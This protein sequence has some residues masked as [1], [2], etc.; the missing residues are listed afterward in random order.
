MRVTRLRA[1]AAA[2]AAAALLLAG[3]AESERDGGD[4][5]GD[6][7]NDA[8]FIFGAEGEVLALDPTYT[9]DSI[10]S[11]L[12]GQ[13]YDTLVRLT[14]GTVD[15][16]GGLAETWESDDTGTVWTFNL[17]EGVTFHDETAFN[18]EA[19]C[20]NFD[21]WHNLPPGINQ[22]PDMSYYWQQFSGGFA[23]NEEGRDDLSEPN[24]VSCEATD[25][26]TAVITLRNPTSRM[27]GLLVRQQFA[28]HSP[29]ALEEWDADNIGGT[30][31]APEFPEYATAHP[32]GTGPFKFE[33][34]DQA[35]GEV[36]MVRNED[37]WEEPATIAR[38]VFKA[39][40]DENA[41]RQA[42][43]S[44]EIHAY[45]QPP[46]ADW[47]TLESEEMRLEIRDSLNLL[48]IAFTQNSNEALED[49]RVRQALAHALDRQAMVTAV[50]AEGAEVATQFM[51]PALSGWNPDVPTYDY[52]PDRARDLLADAGY[53]EGELEIDFYWP[54]DV[55][56]P[57]MP[58][59]QSIFEL[60]QADLDEVGV[61]VNAVS[62]PWTPNYLSNVQNGEADLHFLGWTAD[63]PHAYNFLGTWFSRQLPQWGFDN[64][65]IFDGLAEADSE[66][67]EA[68][69]TAMFEQLNAEIM[70]YLPG[71]PIS[72]TP[73]AMVFAPNVTGVS[74]SPLLDERFGT[75]QIG[76]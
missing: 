23:E 62:E 67:D 4:D 44:G 39:I 61:T 68:A 74:A 56:R 50:M 7:D 12:N 1:V 5:T 8:T 66:A 46:P 75:A 6:T 52:D 51:P 71:I 16:E 69:Q 43:L 19:V 15:I 72:H 65:A 32:T 9:S 13:I 27:V 38:L 26:L 73:V 76:E 45:D 42:L 37:S 48:Y 64:Q 40:P 30:P 53:E 33:S 58:D 31:A 34:W 21:R 24:Y 57:Y 17:R 10:S 63:Y 29:A 20:Y 49:I 25:E 14:P 22:S 2:G 11:R 60:F 35:T 18:A 55:T 36:V 41:R 59:P 70:E 54:T 28:M 3:C 47:A